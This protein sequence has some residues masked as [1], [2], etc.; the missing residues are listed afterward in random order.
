[1]GETTLYEYLRKPS[2]EFQMFLKFPSNL[3]ETCQQCKYLDWVEIL[4]IA[5]GVAWLLTCEEKL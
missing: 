2:N 4:Q 1:M 3:S 5:I